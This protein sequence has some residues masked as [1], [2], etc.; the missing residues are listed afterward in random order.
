[1]SAANRTERAGAFHV[2]LRT[3][4]KPSRRVLVSA[5]NRTGDSDIGGPACKGALRRL[6][7]ATGLSAKRD[8]TTALE[9]TIKKT[10]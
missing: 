9:V 3:L 1:M 5:A 8:Q 6:T 4:P 10:L 7:S 2:V